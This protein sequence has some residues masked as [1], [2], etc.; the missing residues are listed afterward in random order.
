MSPEPLT[1]EQENQIQQAVALYQSRR[2]AEAGARFAELRELFPREP[3]LLTYLGTIALQLGDTE[4]GV[5]FLGES[6]VLNPRQPQVLLNRAVGLSFLGRLD[7]ALENCEQAL[8]LKSDYLEALNT[9]GNLLQ[10][11][12]KKEEA[13]AS[14]SRA[15]AL[16][17]DSAEAHHQRGTAMQDLGRLPEALE[18]YDRALAL[19][20]GYAEAHYNRATAL[21]A[22]HRLSE[23]LAGYDQALALKPGYAWAHHNRATVLQEMDQLEEALAA[24]DRALALQ[25]QANSH[26]SRANTLR[27][28]HRLGEALAAYDQALALNPRYAEAYNNRGTLLQEMKEPEKAMASFNQALVC[29]PLNPEARNN[30]GNLF[31]ELHHPAEA[32]LDYDQAVEWNPGYAEAHN[33]RGTVLQDLKRTGEALAAY[34]RALT[35]SPGHAAAHW[36]KSQLLLLLGDYAQGW[37]LYEWRWKAVLKDRVRSFSQPLWLGQEPLEGKT[38]LIHSE[39]GYGDDIQMVRYA[40]LAQKAG[41][42]VVLEVPRRLLSLFGTL[43]GSPALVEKGGSLP[44]FDLHCP[45]MSLPLAF[46]ARVE[47]LPAAAPYLFVDPAKREIWRERLGPKSRPRVGLVWSG[48][49]ENKNDFHRSLPLEKLRPL[50]DLPLEFHSLQKEYR[51]GDE[52]LLAGLSLRDHQAQQADFSDTA[53]LMAEM[54][55]ILS[56]DTATAHLAGALGLKVWI[57]LSFVPDYRWMLER[58][59]S[60]WYPTATLFR[61]TE[62]GEWGT[63]LEEVKAKMDGKEGLP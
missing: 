27:R 25:P 17:P 59:D 1:P 14:Y 46:Q 37:P 57:L 8:A 11:L 61:Q 54:D 43:P 52:A 7:E 2:L 33:N 16:Q 51:N 6:I 41:A 18:S 15:A 31:K 45:M 23:A 60:P 58:A 39:Q 50:L 40:A 63:V 55:L 10:R 30:R 3:R 48:R 38:L 24:Y 20:P 19:Q 49:A 28:L 12:G 62:W 9:R 4:K 53:S 36:N 35:L 29:K 21:Q 26:Y 47:N 32:L 5:G 22:L 44:L 42:R 56:V 13:L 34:D